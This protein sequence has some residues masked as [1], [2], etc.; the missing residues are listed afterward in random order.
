V[1]PLRHEDTPGMTADIKAAQAANEMMQNFEH[2]DLLDVLPFVP[3]PWSAA[4]EARA[5]GDEWRALV[6]GTWISCGGAVQEDEV[7]RWMRTG[8]PPAM[9]AEAAIKRAMG[10]IREAAAELSVEKNYRPAIAL[11][12]AERIIAEETGVEVTP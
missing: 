4:I 8:T 5:R 7:D 10:R 9:V 12:M 2:V 11:G 6:P 1:I 3:V